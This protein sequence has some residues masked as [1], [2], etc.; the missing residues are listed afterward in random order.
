MRE[1]TCSFAHFQLTH[2]RQ[3]MGE[4][5]G[6]YGV[7]LTTRGCLHTEYTGCSWSLLHQLKDSFTFTLVTHSKKKLSSN[8][9]LLPRWT[10]IEAVEFRDQICYPGPQ[11][12]QT[13][14]WRES[15]STVTWL[16][17]EAEDGGK[18]FASSSCFCWRGRSNSGNTSELFLPPLRWV[19]P[20]TH[21]LPPPRPHGLLWLLTFDHSYISCSS[22]Q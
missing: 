19:S 12:G 16:Y 1:P 13:R 11:N 21:L 15:I 10:G 17:H 18:H 22:L 2:I 4:D 9:L 20:S 3:E 7:T 8:L 6:Y 14:P 5:G